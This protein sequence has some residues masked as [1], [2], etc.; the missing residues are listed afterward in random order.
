MCMKH[1]FC[2]RTCVSPGSKG[3]KKRAHFSK[4]RME[5]LI[6]PKEKREVEEEKKIGKQNIYTP[7]SNP[8]TQVRV[9]SPQ[10]YAKVVVAVRRSYFPNDFFLCQRQNPRAS[11]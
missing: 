2:Y 3:K 9:S 7:I 6:S 11:V 8:L 5:K 10:I 1:K 4:D